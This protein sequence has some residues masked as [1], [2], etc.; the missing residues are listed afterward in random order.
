M[1][2]KAPSSSTDNL[3]GPITLSATPIADPR[4]LANVTIKV[5]DVQKAH[6]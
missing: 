3:F 1:T 5:H 2:Y 4:R 6:L